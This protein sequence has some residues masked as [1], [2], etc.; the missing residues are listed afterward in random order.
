MDEI[1]LKY[2]LDKKGHETLKG[3]FKSSI[4]KTVDTI[5]FIYILGDGN[6]IR[7][8]EEKFKGSK[9]YY[10]TYKQGISRSPKVMLRIE[11][12]VQITS[13]TYVALVSLL[14]EPTYSY[15][16]LRDQWDSYD[17]ERYQL[18]QFRFSTGTFYLYELEIEFNDITQR[19]DIEQKTETL[20]KSLGIEYCKGL[21]PK[22]ER[23]QATLDE[24][25]NDNSILNDR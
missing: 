18:D 19:Q 22:Y 12:D 4:E 13:E 25:R 2:G 23:Y 6:C 10:L 20:L 14:P 7:L 21:F 5:N 8:R 3:R 1:E 24:E 16:T 9:T 15:E 17:G 11:D